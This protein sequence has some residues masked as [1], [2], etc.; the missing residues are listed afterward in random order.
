[1][2]LKSV[3]LCVMYLVMFVGAG[4]AESR[5]VVGKVIGIADGDTITVLDQD[6]KQHRI[7][8]YG[9]DCP[10]SGQPYGW[11][12]KTH[13][14]RLATGKQAM[15]NV[16]DTDRYGRVV[17]VV[18]VGSV[19]VN[20][21]LIESGYAWHYGKYCHASFCSNWQELEGRAR[22]ASVGLWSNDDAIPPWEWRKTGS[23]KR[24][25]SRDAASSGGL[26][27]NVKSHVFHS[28]SCRYYDCKN[29][30]ALF[31]NRSA[32]VSSG[33]TPCGLCRP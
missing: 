21:S 30:T 25:V 18:T 13:T 5:T 8:L 12:A 24:R 10:E 3:V 27:G 4:T 1:M 11:A 31:S 6:K 33:F 29:C 32:A 28:P 23:G 14:A 17:G 20:R 16:Y 7:R 26:H 19:N 22:K 2:G 15:V 9:I